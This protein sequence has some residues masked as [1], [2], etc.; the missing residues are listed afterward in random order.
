MNGQCGA[1][2]Y[3]SPLQKGFIPGTEGCFEHNFALNCA[4]EDAR[5]NS[6]EI[7]IAWL[8]LA[9]AFGSIPHAHIVR[10]LVEMAMPNTLVRLITEMYEGVSTQIEASSGTTPRVEITRG[11]R[12]GDP[13]SPLLFNLAIEP[14]LRAA[15][16]R[17]ETAGYQLGLRKLCVLAYVDDAVLIARSAGALDTLLHAVSTAATWSGLRFKPRK[18]ATLHLHHTWRNARCCRRCSP[19]KEEP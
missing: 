19:S 3:H 13:L 10:T 5:R 17:K 16:V 9:D 11:V 12:Q 2:D 6:K 14:L 4:L 8:D 1:G 7:V 18:C 15:L